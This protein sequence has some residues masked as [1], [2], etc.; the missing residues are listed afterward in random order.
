MALLV[1]AGAV[2]LGKDAEVADQLGGR[3]EAVDVHD[4]GDQDRGRG[5]ADAGDGDDLDVGRAGQV[6]E[7]G[8]QQLP[9]VLLGFLAV[10]DLS[11]QL[12]DQRL[13]HGAAQRR[14]RLLRG[15]VQRLGLLVGQ[16]RDLLQGGAV[17]LG[18]AF[19]GGILV[20][21]PQHPAGG[22][23]VGQG[24][25]FGEGAGQEVVESVDGLGRLF[26]LGLQA[27]GDFAQ[28][29]HRRGRG[30]RRV[31]SLDDGEACHGLALGVVGGAF[32]EVRLLIILVALGLADGQGHG[33]VEA[34]EELFEVDGVLAGGIDA[35][36]E[37]SLGMLFAATAS[38]VPP[39]PDSRR[40]SPSR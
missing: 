17:G 35:D 9:Q 20:E 28:Q 8:G 16:I 25:E 34:A 3:R 30:G 10:T 4:L 11:H 26:D 33:Q 6:R 37:V 36:V 5:L 29:D 21:E 40:G 7:G 38:G 12:A 39:R 13:G 22:D 14:H 24:G 1:D 27:A 15:L 32:G 31:G 23:V 2:L 19:G 18:D